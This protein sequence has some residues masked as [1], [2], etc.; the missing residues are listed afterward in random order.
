MSLLTKKQFAEHCQVGTNYLH[1][2][3]KRG[4]V[5]VNGA[6]LI[7]TENEFNRA[8]M[9]KRLSKN[10]PAAP[11]ANSTEAF[12]ADASKSVKEKT[13]ALNKFLSDLDDS[14]IPPLAVSVKKSKYLS[15]IKIEKEIEKLKFDIAKRKGEVVPSEL[16]KPVFLQHNQSIVTEFKNVI[17][18]V[19]R[20]FAKES[21]LSPNKTAEITGVLTSTINTAITKATHLTSKS[22]L[23]II[24]DHTERRGAGE[25]R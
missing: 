5:I 6:G 10:P 2:P 15:N 16:M 19:L 18:E 11:P 17:D 1:A 13:A 22:I 20:L 9:E 7:D 25:H 8:F 12:I 21:S 23:A 24:K 4:N 14:E 3:I